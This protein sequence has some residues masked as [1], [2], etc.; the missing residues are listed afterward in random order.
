MRKR[1]YGELFSYSFLISP[2]YMIFLPYRARKECSDQCPQSWWQWQL[3]Y[4]GFFSKG[5]PYSESRQKLKRSHPPEKY[6]YIFTHSY[7]SWLFFFV[8]RKL[9]CITFKD[10][11]MVVCIRYSK[12]KE[13]LL[14]EQG[15]TLFCDGCWKNIFRYSRPCTNFFSCERFQSK[16]SYE[17][18]IS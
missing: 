2:N 8:F 10:R 15:E 3:L 18:K 4:T 9:Y 13:L 1:A 12:N 6:E 11:N 14:Q 7:Q 16:K 17:E 5:S